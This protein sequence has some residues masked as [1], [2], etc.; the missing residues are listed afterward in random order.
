[1][2]TDL[3]ALLELL[4]GSKEYQ[5]IVE[6]LNRESRVSASILESAKPFFVSAIHSRLRAPILLVTAYPDSGE[7]LL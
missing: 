7:I 5:G 4:E 2:A 3:H 6:A 1:M